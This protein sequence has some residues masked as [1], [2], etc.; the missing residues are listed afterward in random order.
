MVVHCSM[1]GGWWY[2]LAWLS[3]NIITVCQ[4]QLVLEW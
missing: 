1:L 4:A 3:V 2:G